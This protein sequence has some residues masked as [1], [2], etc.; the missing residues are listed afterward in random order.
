ML[1]L[2]WRDQESSPWFDPVP[3]WSDSLIPPLTDGNDPLTEVIVPLD[4]IA[5]SFTP[6]PPPTVD[7]SEG[8]DR[9]TVSAL[10]VWSPVSVIVED[11][12]GRSTD[13]EDGACTGREKGGSAT[14]RR[15]DRISGSTI[16][17]NLTSL[18]AKKSRARLARFV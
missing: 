7:G 6:P 1:V 11:E 14:N 2:I 16:L 3:P 18:R 8:E 17:F 12:T 9:E 5:Q 13:P 10:V 15:A 4:C